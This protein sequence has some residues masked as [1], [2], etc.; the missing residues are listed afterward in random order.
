MMLHHRRNGSVDSSPK[1]VYPTKFLMFGLQELGLTAE[2][3]KYGS[4][5]MA[6]GDACARLVWSL[7]SSECLR[8][9]STRA[10]RASLLLLC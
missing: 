4:P 6:D 2:L 8:H 3:A 7:P 10:S 5:S 1:T 9:I